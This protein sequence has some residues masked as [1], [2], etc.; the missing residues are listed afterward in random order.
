MRQVDSFMSSRQWDPET[1]NRGGRVI[2]MLSENTLQGA[3]D[4]IPMSF[5]GQD[6]KLTK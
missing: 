1:A 3:L 5:L 6:R 2:E 4:E